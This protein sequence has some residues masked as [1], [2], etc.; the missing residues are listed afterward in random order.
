L[1]NE[2]FPAVRQYCIERK[3]DFQAVDL[4]LG[5]SDQAAAS[6]ETINICLEELERCQ[7]LS[8]K[9]NLLILLGNRYGWEPLP[10]SIE[11]SEFEQIEKYLTEH[12]FDDAKLM[13]LYYRMDENCIPHSY[14]LKNREEHSDGGNAEDDEQILLSAFRK[15]VVKLGFPEDT[16]DKYFLSAT[17]Y[18][19]AKGVNY[20][21][22]ISI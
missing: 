22:I 15:A 20:C 14:V 8:A 6:N 16:Q 18:E 17:G 21:R 2:V 19:V 4:R 5:I 7:R 11:A 10:G 13:R 3:F 9:P 12:H 1:Q